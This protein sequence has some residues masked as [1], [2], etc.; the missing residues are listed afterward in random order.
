MQHVGCK[1]SLPLSIFGGFIFT[2][3][4]SRM[5]QQR[6]MLVI[7]R[8]NGRSAHPFGMSNDSNA[9][10]LSGWSRNELVLDRDH[11]V[12]KAKVNSRL[13]FLRCDVRRAKESDSA[14]YAPF[15]LAKRAMG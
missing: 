10:S 14:R 1:Y 4:G 9:E 6:L 12:I 11:Q 8:T 3:V 5:S 13:L 7:F 2:A 15:C